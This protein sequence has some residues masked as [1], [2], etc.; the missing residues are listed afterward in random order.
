[1]RT[2]RK[3]L[4]SVLTVALMAIFLMNGC[5]WEDGGSFN[6][7][8]GAG[9]DVNISGMYT[10]RSGELVAG[11]S[12]ASLLITQIGNGLEVRDSNNSL[13]TGSVGSPGVMGRAS[14]GGAYSAGEEMLQSQIS[15]FGKNALTGTDMSFAGIIR[16]VALEDVRGSTVTATTTTDSVDATA[17]N[18]LGVTSIDIVAPPVTISDATTITSE[19][20]NGVTVE[21]VNE[22]TTTFIITDANTLFIL[23]GHWVEGGAVAAVSGHARSSAGSF[24]TTAT[25]TTP[26]R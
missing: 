15:F 16:A 2:R 6:T 5:D 25:T 14:L 24:S 18:N 7:S 4:I 19:D 3:S 11:M 8:K 10:A 9:A 22:A 12:I 23:E 26:R 13:Y 1:M 17:T 21:N 20:S